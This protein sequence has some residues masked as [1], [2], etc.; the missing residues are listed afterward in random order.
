MQNKPILIINLGKQFG[1]TEKYVLDIV[2]Y[3]T[4]K[5]IPY[6]VCARKNS[7]FSKYI[8][9]RCI[10]LDITKFSILKDVFKLRKFIKNNHIKL[11][12][13]NGILD[14]FFVRLAT[15]ISN[16]STISTVHGKIEIDQ[17]N[18][19][20]LKKYIY[21]KLFYMNSKWLI[22]YI[23]V[24][25]DI[26]NYM[27]EKNIPKLKIK[28]INHGININEYSRQQYID[29]G[30]INILAVGRLETVKN[31]SLLIKAIEYLNKNFNK[32]YMLYIFGE[33]IDKK[34][35]IDEINELKLNNYVKLMGFYSKPFNHQIISNINC[36]VQPSI[37]ESFGYTVIESMISM[38]PVIVSDVGGMNYVK[39]NDTG[40]TFQSNNLEQLCKKINECVGSEN[41]NQIKN[42]AYNM[43][44][45]KFNKESSLKVLLK[46]YEEVC[47]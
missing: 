25:E 16:V 21:C 32:E 2:S 39:D 37:Y 7:E 19:S 45:E 44:I 20:N 6:F 4:E 9:S 24:S 43:V 14:N 17:G 28:L 3:L 15:L 31:Y 22:K 26:Y 47:K 30:K 41:I 23:A 36:F 46:I 27:I 38:I 1:G 5:N 13:S 35:L 33:G 40:F 34:N 8:S 11:I 18:A 29:N 42:N 10:L 12:H